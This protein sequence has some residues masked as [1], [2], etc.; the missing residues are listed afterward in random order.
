MQWSPPRGVT[1]T[2]DMRSGHLWA[3]LCSLCLTCAV[4]SSAWCYADA[5]MCS[6][7]FRA[8]DMQTLTCAMVVS[9]CCY[10]DSEY[11]QSSRLDGVTQTLTCAVVTSGWCYIDSD[12]RSGCLRAVL[13]RLCMTCTVVASGRCCIDPDMRSSH[14]RVLSAQYPGSDV[15]SFVR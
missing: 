15:V 12:M 10:I 13:R 7:H 6:D 9:G 1:Q 5:D 3:V 4:V 14:L 11:V 8:V 2:L